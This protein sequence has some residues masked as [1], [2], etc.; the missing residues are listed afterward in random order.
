[1]WGN[2]FHTKQEKKWH[3][4]RFH[5]GCR[6]S[7]RLKTGA[8]VVLKREKNAMVV[9]PFEQYIQQD[10]KKSQ[11]SLSKALTVCSHETHSLFSILH[12]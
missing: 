10:K 1:M 2:L 5:R 7:S 9:A 12:V 6:Y 4:H 8:K 3:D 11:Q